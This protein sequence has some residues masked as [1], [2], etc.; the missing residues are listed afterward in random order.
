MGKTKSK[1]E[2]KNKGEW[3]ESYV[4][5]RILA[6]GV[7]R[8]ASDLSKRIRVSAIRVRY[9]EVM[10]HYRIDEDIVSVFDENDLRVGEFDRDTALRLADRLLSEIS[11]GKG[12]AITIS[13]ASEI[14]S[15]LCLPKLSSQS[16]RVKEDV[17]LATTDSATGE[18]YFQGYSIKS[19]LGGSATLFNASQETTAITY[20]FEEHDPAL[21]KKANSY[22]KSTTPRD[23]VKKRVEC[24][25][26]LTIREVRYRSST[27]EG[28]LSLI[29]AALPEIYARL[30]LESNLVK[31]K[32]IAEVIQK[33]ALRSTIDAKNYTLLEYISYKVRNLLSEMSLGMTAGT[34]WYGASSVT[35]GFLIVTTDC[36]TITCHMT[37]DRIS[38]LEYLL[39]A[40]K[41]D[42]PS[43]G[44]HGSN[45]LIEIVDGSDKRMAMTLN[46]QIR[47]VPEKELYRVI[48]DIAK[49]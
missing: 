4:V 44:R 41:F 39:R 18:Q 34:R 47:W 17:I 45:E 10:R 22:N 40:T 26:D 32:R 5:L 43:T 36:T 9:S 42:T 7:V 31:G 49:S 24:I 16:S 30:V 28:N 6:E 37:Q 29:D 13:N 27:F 15:T 48:N 33:H 11:A 38:Y 2:S 20:V 8:D 23:Y 46:S 14:A 19:Y 35:G 3:S 1:S 12:R 25:A 21:I